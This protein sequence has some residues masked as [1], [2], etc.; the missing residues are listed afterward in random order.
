MAVIEAINP[1]WYGQKRRHSTAAKKGWRRRH[2]SANPR[3]RVA[4]SRRRHRNP[5]RNPAGIPL[6]QN[7]TLQDVMVGGASFMLVQKASEVAKQI[8][9]AD[10]G[11]KTIT[12]VA[13][14]MAVDAALPKSKQAAVL[15]G[16]L[17][18]ALGA[19]NMLTGG[20]YG[21]QTTGSA[22]IATGRRYML[23]SPVAPLGVGI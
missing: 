6:L 9:W 14:G 13:V 21:M 5:L 18:A 19:L 4:Q 8:G 17:P 1:S 20:Q 23:A 15:A 3:R 11:V 16:L 7:V 2:R 22:H 10:V 12:A